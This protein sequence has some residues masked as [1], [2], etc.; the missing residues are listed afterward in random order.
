MKTTVE[1]QAPI[2]GARARLVRWPPVLIL[3]PVG[4]AIRSSV[5]FPRPCD[6]NNSNR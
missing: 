2:I 1:H 3:W 6:S 4:R 5:S